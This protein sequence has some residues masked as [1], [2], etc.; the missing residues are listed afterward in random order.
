MPTLEIDEHIAHLEDDGKRLARAAAAAGLDAAVP[1]CPG[2]DVRALVAHIGGV[3]RWACS[4]LTTGRTR[5]TSAEEDAAYFE[6]VADPELVPW[7][8]TGHAALVAAFRRASPELDCWTFLPGSVSPLAFWSR[9]QA[10]E[11]AIHRVDAEA[12][13]GLES[14]CDAGFAADGIDELLCGFLARPRGRLV[15]DPPVALGVEA[16]DTGRAWTLRIERDRR[17][18]TRGAAPADCRVRGRAADLYLL[19][20]NRRGIDDRLLVEGN[21][22]MLDLW[23]ERAVIR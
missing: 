12:A 13:A 3:H 19:L 7:F 1:T 11:T 4:Y 2:W 6:A 10:H 17:V 23:R 8:R 16:T 22:D 21:R 14:E 20:W 9:R 15:S 18:A 5:V